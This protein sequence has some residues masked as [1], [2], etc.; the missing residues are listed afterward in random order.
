MYEGHLNLHP[1]LTPEM[2]KTY[3]FYEGI[4]TFL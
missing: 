2:A 1:T 4:G 3:I